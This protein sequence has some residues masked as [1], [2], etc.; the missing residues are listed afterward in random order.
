ME[1]LISVIVPVFNTEKYLDRCVESI[2]DQ[3]YKNIEIILVDDGSTDLSGKMCDD[4][5]REEK[6]II[7]IHQKNKGAN[8]ARKN[9]VQKAKGEYIC[10]VDS[11][12]YVERDY[13]S[14]LI[15]KIEEAD[16][17]TSGCNWVLTNGMELKE[18]DFFAPGNYEEE[19]AIRFVHSHMIYNYANPRDNY[20]GMLT[21]MVGKLFKKD[22]A[23]LVFKEIDN[24]IQFGEDVV[25]V[26]SYLVRCKRITITDKAF[27]NYCH[28]YD[29]AT[30]KKMDRFLDS[31]ERIYNCLS[32]QFAGN[33]LEQELMLQL[34]SYIY[35]RLK[36]AP[37]YLK[38]N[39]LISRPVYE[40]PFWG[41]FIGKRVILYGAGRVGIDYY[42]EIMKKN[43]FS[44][45]AWI[46]K[47]YKDIIFPSIPPISG[48]DTIKST[49]YDI[50][51]LSVGNRL[52]KNIEDEL[53]S[54]GV[55]RNVIFWLPPKVIT[56]YD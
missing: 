7:A 12:D 49:S 11:D 37:H 25:F 3:T 28:R 39:K 35:F 5:E 1:S 56:Y 54:F 20:R 9:G 26:F 51:V 23:S 27:Y 29:S 13:V 42:Q 44:I 18:Q 34:E 36:M 41:K 40:F 48:M 15:E 22:L 16:V 8:Y 43:E 55:P 32:F 10:F 31:L 47:N 30:H 24:N 19:E 38:F 21:Y 52:H 33:P 2:R 45:V 46:D 17:C 6:N 4:Y 14:N 50:I 53:V